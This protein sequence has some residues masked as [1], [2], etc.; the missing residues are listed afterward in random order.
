MLLKYNCYPLDNFDIFLL[1][2]EFLDDLTYKI[3]PNIIVFNIN[4][5]SS[6]PLGNFLFELKGSTAVS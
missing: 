4:H 2:F 5:Y 3:K 1:L 6:L